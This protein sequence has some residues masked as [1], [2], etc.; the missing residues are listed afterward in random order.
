MIASL[1]LQLGELDPFRS[2]A[3]ACSALSGGAIV[4]P[5]A[6]YALRALARPVRERLAAASR[7]RSGP[8]SR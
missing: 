7:S 3:V 5:F 2:L 8:G 6:Y 1:R 4:L